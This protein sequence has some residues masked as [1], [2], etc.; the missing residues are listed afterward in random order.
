MAKKNTADAAKIHAEWKKYNAQ[1][2]K[3]DEKVDAI[4]TSV[5]TYER[6][7]DYVCS[8]VVETLTNEASAERDA[9]DPNSWYQLEGAIKHAA[10]LVA[11]GLAAANEARPFAQAADDAR[12]L[13]DGLGAPP[14]LRAKWNEIT[15]AKDAR[16]AKWD[17]EAKRDQATR[18]R[19]AEKAERS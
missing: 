3:A 11:R 15:Q 13:K 1:E 8:W 4:R 5:Y 18:R 14:E 17:R 16:L 7:L 12:S 10:D 2:I 9:A 19:E 6:A